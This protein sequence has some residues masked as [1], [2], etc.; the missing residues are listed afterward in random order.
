MRNLRLAPTLA[1]P[2]LI[3]AP[4]ATATVLLLFLLSLETLLALL[5]MRER[6]RRL[7]PR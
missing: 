5:L 2:I 6:S 1:T 3:T 7:A 4:I